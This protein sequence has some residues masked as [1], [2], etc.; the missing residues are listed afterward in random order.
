MT[1]NRSVHPGSSCPL[2]NR[3]WV[4]ARVDV[5]LAVGGGLSVDVELS[6][7]RKR[8][9]FIMM[10]DLD[11]FPR[12]ADIVY[13]LCAYGLVSWRLISAA[14]VVWWG[15]KETVEEWRRPSPWN[16]ASSAT[17][18]KLSALRSPP[19]SPGLIRDLLRGNLGFQKWLLR[20]TKNS[21]GIEFFSRYES[22]KFA[23]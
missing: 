20:G 1:S 10:L 21:P 17:L 7:E 14:L 12:R 2:S 18:E 15:K 23:Y 4:A 9:S 8:R 6:D 22:R 13:G 19:C 3:R 11:L 5:P 16:R